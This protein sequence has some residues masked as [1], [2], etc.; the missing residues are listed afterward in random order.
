MS[1]QVAL[2]CFG[3]VEHVRGV[4]PLEIRQLTCLGEPVAGVLPDGGEHPEPRQA[5]R[6]RALQEEALLNQRLEDE[7]VGFAA[8][9]QT[10]PSETLQDVPV[11]ST[12][13]GNTP[14]QFRALISSSIEASRRVASE[15][16][17][18]FD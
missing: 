4:A 13:V 5:G 2:G 1:E 14:E 17:L 10:L 11:G 12:P 8:S 3:Q 6:V 7:G 9:A 15:A 18:K 16:K